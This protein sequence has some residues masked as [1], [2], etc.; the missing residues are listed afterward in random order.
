MGEAYDAVIVGAGHNGLVVA[1]YLARAGRR[2]LVLERR[3]V[4]GGAAVTEE[5]VPGFRFDS[6]AHRLGWLP[7]RIVSDLDLGRHGLR[8]LPSNPALVALQPGGEA[9]ALWR[10]PARTSA[11]LR[12]FSPGAAERWSSFAGWLGRLARVLR[13]PEGGVM[14]WFDPFDEVRRRQDAERREW[15]DRMEARDAEECGQRDRLHRAAREEQVRQEQD[16]Y[17]SCQLANY[18]R[19][20]IEAYNA[21]MEQW[22]REN[23]PHDDAPPPDPE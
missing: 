8:L 2:V 13:R 10:S 19:A 20:Q 11:A 3:D 22:A 6:G 23:Q 21:D 9:L 4:V 1:G 14:P 16:E 18:N 7:D 5:L 15:Y 17:E 12:R